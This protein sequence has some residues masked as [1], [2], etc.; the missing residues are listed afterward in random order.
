MTLEERDNGVDGYEA[1]EGLPGQETQTDRLQHVLL[2]YA[3]GEFA[4]GYVIELTARVERVGTD[5]G[6]CH[7]CGV[8]SVC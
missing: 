4:E 5:V 8:Y 1:G 7:G 2:P 6:E 3:V